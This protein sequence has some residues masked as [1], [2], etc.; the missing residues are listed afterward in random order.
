MNLLL[1]RGNVMD[2]R[3]QTIENV[4]GGDEKRFENAYQ[5]AVTEAI[6]EAVAWK[7]LALN[8]TLLPHLEDATHQLIEQRLG[9]V[10]HPSVSLPYAPYLRAL[11]QSY[12]QGTLSQNAFKHEAEEHIKLIRNAD[13]VH[14]SSAEPAPHFQQSYQKMFGIY[15]SQAKDRLTRFLGYEPLLEHSLMAELWLFDLMTRD[16]IRLP[17][18]RTAVDFKALTIIRYREILLGQG[19]AAA[20]ASPL[21]GPFRPLDN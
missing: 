14:Y 1:Y 3:Q 17:E 19:K 5:T 12:H 21:L 6:S 13:M 8:A 16:T 4:F 10:P 2:W 18:A 15:G 20:D 7:D 9:Y 11:L